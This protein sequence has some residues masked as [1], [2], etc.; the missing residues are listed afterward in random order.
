[1]NP[2]AL[3]NN[4]DIY[5]RSPIDCKL[6]NEGVANVNDD[7]TEEALSVLRYELETFVCG[8][9]YENGMRIVLETFLK[10]IDE[11]QQPAVW[12]SGFYGS[13][14]S[15]L[16]KMLRAL[17]QNEPFGDG[18]TP[19]E[20][21]SLPQNIMDLFSELDS[22]ASRLGGR[23]AAS[24]TLGSSARGS[25][26][27]A[28]LR[29]IFRSAGLPERYPH[30]RFVMWLKREGILRDA[31]RLVEEDG[32]AWDDE[33]ED[34]YLSDAIHRALAALRPNQFSSASCAEILSNAYKSADDISSSGMTRAISDALSGLHETEGP[35]RR[36]RFPLTMIVL[37]EVQQYIGTD[38]SRSVEIQEAVEACCRDFGGKL[39]FVGTGQTAVTGTVNLKKL[40]GRFTVRV[41][42]SDADA[43][44]VMRKVILAKKPEA[45]PAIEKVMTDNLPEIRR[46]LSGTSIGHRKEDL[47]HFSDDYPM[48]PARMRFWK[49]VLKALDQTGTDSQLRSQLG[50]MHKAIG[51]NLDLPLGNILPADYIYFELADRLLQAR[52]LPRRVHERTTEWRFG[53]Q[54]EHLMARACGLVFLINRLAGNDPEMGV[55]ADT[56]TLADLMM[57]DLT[58]GSAALREALPEALERCVAEKI[59]MRVGDG[60]RI[61]TEESV[62]WND[63]FEAARAALANETY[64]LDAARDDHIRAMLGDILGRTGKDALFVPQGRANKLMRGI[65]AVYDAALPEGSEKR[66]TVWV[67]DGWKTDE[68]SL[69]ADA[70]MAGSASPTVFVFV[71]SAS[72]ELR[73]QIIDHKAAI[74]TLDK[75]GR[76]SSGE[77]ME[78]RGAIETIR[79]IAGARIKEL[80]GEAFASAKVFRGG[81]SETTGANLREAVLEAARGSASRLYPRF[82]EA[83]Q[84]GWAQ[85]CERARNGAAD[86]LES[87][88][89][90]D[91]DRSCQKNPVCRAIIA[92]L[93]SEQSGADIRKNFESPPYGWPRDAIDGAIFVLLQAN[94]IEAT[95]GHG[96][97][98]DHRALARDA[99]GRT[100]FKVESVSLSARERI[101]ARRLMQMMDV[102]AKA[103]DEISSSDIFLRR[104]SEMAKAAGGDAPLPPP[105]PLALL[106]EI[107]G[108]SGNG[109]LLAIYENREEIQA[110]IRESRER[111]REISRRLPLWRTAEGLLAA[112]GDLPEAKMAAREMSD[113]ENARRLLDNPDPVPQVAEELSR[114][115]RDELRRLEGEYDARHAEGVG[116]LK[117]D[118]LWGA[119][120]KEQRSEILRSHNLDIASKPAVATDSPE[121]ILNTVS[122]CS[123]QAFSDRIEALPGRFDRALSMAARILQPEAAQIEIAIPRA[124]FRTE[125]EIDS[126]AENIKAR[127]KAALKDGP[128][129][130]R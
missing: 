34:F 109:R 73:R 51:T 101:E 117:G 65:Y 40:E 86:A 56:G 25:V 107:S 79:D 81:G 89:G 83:D 31:M 69:I 7:R 71:P 50:M 24:G 99:I 114:I 58:A 72:D 20:A 15:H 17:W 6:I 75:M 63:E 94:A 126:W 93:E 110:L 118:E 62:A 92:F 129:Y 105:P 61:Q 103:D 45:K 87:L 44:T 76:P 116:K 21:A 104:L 39:M 2:E 29:L 8:G 12:V 10:N 26:R 1:M 108:L 55:S 47:R 57:D 27:L 36:G 3:M 84:E 80:L 91:A 88:S 74:W 100:G 41:E 35:D 67:R 54:T 46:G 22:R 42:L 122:K 90:G 102:Q 128:V 60:F 28:L 130:I 59:L 112:C 119:L 30:A 37:D 43:D 14:K 4:R 23:H 98:A 68:E 127:L 9:Q 52:V 85:V 38:A 97:A 123:L 48:L 115:L 77:G 13:G 111:G 125:G 18:V 19:R 32:L 33:L 64:R 49:S 120:E 113:I 82:D 78:A 106:S 95:D 5:L 66:I 53:S 96:R 16:A 124:A 11:A 70:R 121:D